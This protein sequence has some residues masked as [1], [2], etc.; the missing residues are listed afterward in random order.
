[1]VAINYFFFFTS[2]VFLP[3]K[4]YNGQKVAKAVMIKDKLTPKTIHCTRLFSI[5]PDINKIN[6][7]MPNMTL[8]KQ[9][10]LPTFFFIKIIFWIIDYKIMKKKNRKYDFIN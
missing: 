8:T 7:M 3:T 4:A 9:S 10:V 5:A 1:M 2:Q 6:S